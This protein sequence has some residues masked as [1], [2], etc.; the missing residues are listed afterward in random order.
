MLECGFLEFSL[1]LKYFRLIFTPSNIA[2]CLPYYITVY[3][4]NQVGRG[5][6]AEGIGFTQECSKHYIETV[7]CIT[8]AVTG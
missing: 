2:E 7:L 4:V 1:S 8:T 6:E 3:A 5:L